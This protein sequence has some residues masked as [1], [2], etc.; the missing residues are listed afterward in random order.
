MTQIYKGYEIV[1]T[2]GQKVHCR[3][4]RFDTW[5]EDAI[6]TNIYKDSLVVSYGFS[7]YFGSFSFSRGNTKTIKRDE[8]AKF[9]RFPDASLVRSAHVALSKEELSSLLR[10]VRDDSDS[11]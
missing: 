6:V 11:D 1:I 5:F 8:I 4:D 10:K 3:S 2:P 9:L 7:E